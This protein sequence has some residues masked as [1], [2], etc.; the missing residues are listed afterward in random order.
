MF[1]TY[2]LMLGESA[3]YRRQIYMHRVKEV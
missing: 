3:F 2:W 1:D